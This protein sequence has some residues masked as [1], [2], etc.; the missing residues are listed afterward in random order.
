MATPAQLV[1]AV[2]KATGVPLPTIVDIDRKLVTANL[3]TK[4]G[5]GLSVARMTPLDAARLLTAVL[6]SPQANASAEAVERYAQTRVDR[7]QSSDKLFGA[8]KL[9]DL[10]ARPAR[11]SFVDALAALIASAS[12]GALAKLLYDAS[13]RLVPSIEVFAF[14]R[15]TKGRIRIAGLPDRDAVR[16]EY[17]LAT[18]DEIPGRGRKA[19]RSR[20]ADESAGDLEQS[21]RVT[22]QTIL[23]IAEV[24]AEE[25]Q[26]E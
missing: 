6:A 3:R 16:V 8:T 21:R 11:D 9:A 20:S 7:A 15:A 19:R 14:T 10:A 18:P 24:L 17:I 25:S 5:R 2:S 23:M 1:N 22:E 26:H 12:T 13:I 4:G